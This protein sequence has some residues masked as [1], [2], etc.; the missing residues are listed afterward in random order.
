MR[1]KRRN[2]RVTTKTSVEDEIVHLRGLEL[3]ATR[4]IHRVKATLIPT[5]RAVLVRNAAAS[6]DILSRVDGAFESKGPGAIRGLTFKDAC[7]HRPNSRP[8]S[9]LA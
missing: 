4:R 5:P 2:G 6:I 9:R 8:A 7:S 1:K 3:K